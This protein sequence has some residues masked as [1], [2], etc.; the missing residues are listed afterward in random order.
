MPTR[1]CSLEYILYLA[2]NMGLP[3]TDSPIDIAFDKTV[4]HHQFLRTK[5]SQLS[6]HFD[7]P[8]EELTKL[9]SP[10]PE[11]FTPSQEVQTFLHDRNSLQYHFFK[12][13]HDDDAPLMKHLLAWGANPNAATNHVRPL[14]VAISQGHV[15]AVECLIE[16]NVKINNDDVE[17]AKC[18]AWFL[19]PARINRS[20]DLYHPAVES[21]Y[22]KPEIESRYLR[23]HPVYAFNNAIA[24]YELVQQKFY[25]DKK[26]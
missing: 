9:R 1:F 8:D 19:D 23:I 17:R 18:W 10:S 26:R 25:N 2:L 20:D 7:Q 11:H 5:P 24:I 22:L 6:S 13:T 21:K 15:H 14:Q 16:H 3:Q 4:Q 12:A